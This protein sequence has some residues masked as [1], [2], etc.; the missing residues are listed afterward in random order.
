M[1]SIDI[2]PHSLAAEVEPLVYKLNPHSAQLINSLFPGKFS[3]YARRLRLVGGFL[4]ERDSFTVSAKSGDFANITE[5][6]LTEFADW[7]I[8]TGL[9][10]PSD[11]KL[12]AAGPNPK[13]EDILPPPSLVA[14]DKFLGARERT[15]LLKVVF[16]LAIQG[17]GYD[18]SASR[19]SAVTEITSDLVKLGIEIS[20][21]TIRRYL[22]E[23]VRA[24]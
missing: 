13:P 10:I 23:G 3:E 18:P 14:N 19:G 21:D 12:N 22:K 17:Y 9:E 15:N 24:D 5:I 16:G 7:A 11:M 2:D 20:D 4:A 6:R 8:K 1:L